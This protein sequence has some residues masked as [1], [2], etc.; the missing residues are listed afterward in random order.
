M[1][2]PS[3]AGRA[4]I[5]RVLT[6]PLSLSGGFDFAAVAKRTPGFVGA[7]LQARPPLHAHLRPHLL[8]LV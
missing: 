2:I 4:S 5:L 8:S 3:E 7:D 6:R 1:S